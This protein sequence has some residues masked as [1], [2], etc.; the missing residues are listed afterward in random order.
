VIFSERKIRETLNEA[1]RIKGQI[2]KFVILFLAGLCSCVQISAQV[3]TPSSAQPRKAR[4][5]GVRAGPVIVENRP[6]APQVVTILHRLTGFKTFRLLLRSGDVSAIARQDDA[7]QFNSEVHT[8]VIAGLA[9]DDCQTIAA[10]L[11]EAEAETAPPP[12][13]PFAPH[14]PA[15]LVA[16]PSLLSPLSPA[17]MPAPDQSM[18]TVLGNIFES[19]DVM[20]IGRNGKH[21]TAQYVG[22][23]GATGLSVLK[24]SEKSLPEIV[25]A[26]EEVIIVGQHLRLFGPAPVAEIEPSTGGTVYV[27]MGETEGRVTSV[28][29]AP[30]G[31]IARLKIRSTT[32]S[33]ANI[34]GIAINDAGETVGIINAVEGSEATILPSAMIRSAAKRVLGRQSSVPR[35]WLGVR[36]EP[37]GAVPLEQILR[38][39]WQ[40]ERA[41]SLFEQHR[42]IL[43]TSVAPGSPAAVAALRAGD[44]ILRV[45]DGD[46]RNADDFS[47]FLEEAGSGSSVRFT[48]ARPG[49]LA[50]EAV[51]VKL[52]ESPD[53]LFGLRMP[54]G[55]AAQMVE[56]GSL[57]A[58][59]IETVALKRGVASRF[60]ANG[61]LLVVY[62]RPSAAA[63]N[64]GLRPGDVI[65]AIDGQQISS[66]SGP[67][68]L[69][70]IPGASHSFR[71]VR[72]KEKLVLTIVSTS[73]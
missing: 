2:N 43:L 54:E 49:G 32:L 33:S 71:V 44:V 50:P 12:P 5:T 65:E 42:G 69:A 4:T 30:D 23:D 21:L 57:I 38:G 26:K 52:S 31:S 9:L 55:R 72:N 27:R 17:A 39:G 6:S 64:A 73:K 41:R 58:H 47:W 45:N 18:T 19:P 35:P 13:P 7:F 46:V 34:G 68:N 37:V 60:G 16:L 15:A 62:V 70:T 25:N 28:T 20:V 8:N 51:M 66:P 48:V 61:G 1:M 59:G 22:L 24:L 29:R 14:A 10:W 67:I 3:A 11:P 40:P 63:F 56:P 53:P 36:G